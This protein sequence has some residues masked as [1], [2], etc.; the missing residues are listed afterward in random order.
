[1]GGGIERENPFQFVPAV[2]T[3]Y[4]HRH[5]GCHALPR[6]EH[7]P[8]EQYWQ[9]L[10]SS[11]NFPSHPLVSP[12]QCFPFPGGNHMSFLFSILTSMQHICVGKSIRLVRYVSLSLDPAVRSMLPVI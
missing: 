3:I 5:M 9:D 11:S 7:F 4:V 10:V 8:W 6:N 1:M 2:F 12:V